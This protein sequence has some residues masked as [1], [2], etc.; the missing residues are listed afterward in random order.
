MPD[1]LVTNS[2]SSKVIFLLVGRSMTNKM[3]MD[4]NTNQHALEHQDQQRDL[5]RHGDG[6]CARFIRLKLISG[7]KA[8]YRFTL[9]IDVTLRC[10]MGA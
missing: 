1:I 3:P 7:K 6:D 8:T 4:A 2:Y 10:M 9:D 5:D